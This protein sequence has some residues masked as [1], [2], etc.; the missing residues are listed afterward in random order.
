MQCGRIWD[1]KEGGMTKTLRWQCLRSER[2]FTPSSGAYPSLPFLSLD[3]QRQ[4]QLSNCFRRLVVE[5]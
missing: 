2:A 3:A 4:R 5:N 1:S